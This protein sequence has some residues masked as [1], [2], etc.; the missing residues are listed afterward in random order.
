MLKLDWSS[1][2]SSPCKLTG[3]IPVT[4]WCFVRMVWPT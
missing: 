4:V 3:L 1:V 2:T